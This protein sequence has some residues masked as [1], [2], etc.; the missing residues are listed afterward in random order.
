MKSLINKKK[1]GNNNI[2]SFNG[3]PI[4]DTI[5]CANAFNR[6]FHLGHGGISFLTNTNRSRY[7][8]KNYGKADHQQGFRKHRSTTTTLHHINNKISNGLNCKNRFRTTVMIND[9]FFNK[10]TIQH[11]KMDLQ[12]HKGSSNVC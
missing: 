3:K 4:S 9:Q 1:D 5:A 6:Q 12:L 11:Q 8:C 2:I 7:Y 10:Y